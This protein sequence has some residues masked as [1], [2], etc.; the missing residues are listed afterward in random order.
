MSRRAEVIATGAELL[1]GRTLNRH[2]HVL[3]GLLAGLATLQPQ[4]LALMHGSSHAG[5][6]GPMLTELA[7]AIQQVFGDAPPRP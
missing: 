2:G 4:T 1:Q 3:G 7:S 6:G 5:A